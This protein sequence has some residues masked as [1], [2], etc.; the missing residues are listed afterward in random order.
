[1]FYVRLLR[2]GQIQRPGLTCTAAA[3]F[4]SPFQTT[5]ENPSPGATT[6]VSPGRKVTR[7]GPRIILP[8]E[9]LLSE[10]SS[11]PVRVSQSLTTFESPSVPNAARVIPSGANPTEAISPRWPQNTW[12][13]SP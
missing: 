7:R 1:M 9:G 12:R 2:D 13:G 11:A 3:A 10:Q 8:F 5:N 6:D 4:G